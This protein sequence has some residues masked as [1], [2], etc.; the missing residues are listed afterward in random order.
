MFTTS[1]HRK[2]YPNNPR[3]KNFSFANS[4]NR[5]QQQI[6]A[7]SLLKD[8][9]TQLKQDLAIGKNVEDYVANLKN[10]STEDI[11][12]KMWSN[13]QTQE[14]DKV[15]PYKYFSIPA[16]SVSSERLFSDTSNHILARRTRLA[17]S[18]VN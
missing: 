12:A 8:L 2:S 10:V 3:I 7:K 14:E 16:I 9:Y 17:S 15:I 13:N 11:F 1:K 6:Q 5:V 18:L 4:F